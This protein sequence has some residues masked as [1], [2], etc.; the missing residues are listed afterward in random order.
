MS[1]GGKKSIQLLSIAFAAVFGVLYVFQMNSASMKAYTIRDL[2]SRRREL[3]RDEDRLLTEVDRL[4]SLSSI[5]ERQAF[6][7]LVQPEHVK[8]IKVSTS[9]VALG[10]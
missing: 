9:E 6:L 5:A 1:E 7:G 2:E 10:K 3:V 8:F 4:R